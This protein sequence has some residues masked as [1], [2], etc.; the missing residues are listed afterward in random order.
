[1]LKIQSSPVRKAG[2]V[3]WELK[4]DNDAVNAGAWGSGVTAVGAILATPEDAHIW[5]WL[6]S[7]VVTGL[8]GV[9]SSAVAVVLKHYLGELKER[10]RLK[11]PERD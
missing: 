10:R 4:V 3:Y 5:L 8:F 6:V 1:M 2:S 11:E 7:L 9:A